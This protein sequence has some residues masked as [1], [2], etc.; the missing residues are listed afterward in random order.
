MKVEIAHN[1]VLIV[2]AGHFG[3]RAARIIA[4]RGN[5][6]IFVIDVDK[7]RLARLNGLPVTAL[8]CDGIRFL[9]EN[10]PFLMPSNTIVPALPLH[11]AYE[12]LRG[13]LPD[14]L[15]IRRISVPAEVAEFVPHAWP[16]G[17]G[18]LLVSYADFVCPDDCPEP[19]ACTI[20]GEQRPRPLYALLGTLGLTGFNVHVIRSR[21]LAPGLGGYRAADLKA[22]AE[23]VGEGRWLLASACKCHGILTAF[24]IRTGQDQQD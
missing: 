13:I 5:S 17:E 23:T 9:I 16:G 14:K 21:Q 1:A 18:S 7:E 6:Q 2:G 11:L 22:A 4:E 20:T 19:A 12:W 10:D 15:Q 3:E 8:R 24:E